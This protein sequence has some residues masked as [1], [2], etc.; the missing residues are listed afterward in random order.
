MRQIWLAFVVLCLS[1]SAMAANRIEEWNQDLDVLETRLAA[2][3]PKFKPCGLSPEIKTEFAQLRQN[4]EHLSDAEVSVAVQ[5]LLA[6]VGDGHTLLFPFG[7]K[8][9]ALHR[10]PVML[11][12][13][14]D[15]LFVVQAS[16]AKAV[17]RLSPYISHDNDMQLRWA[18]PFYATIT[19]FLVAIGGAKRADAATLTFD[20]GESITFASADIDPSKL[21]LKLPTPQHRD[22]NFWFTKLADDTLYIQL[23]AIADAPDKSLSA[24][25]NELHSALA[26]VHRAILDLRLNNGGDAR[27]ANDVLK[28]LIAFDT[29]GGKLAVLTS[30]MTFS[31]AQTLAT[32]LD[33]W[34]NATFVGEP[35]GSRPNHYGNERSFALPSS[36]LRG[37]IAS[38]LNQPI[39]AN[40]DRET[41]LPDVVVTQTAEQY[42]RRADPVLEAAL[43][44]IR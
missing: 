34:T 44:R 27:K 24:F 11:W 1:F 5:R 40:D 26:G 14:D 2:V 41:I 16:D 22:V 38:G 18:A 33:E 4:L 6:R 19:E 28:A 3:H 7:M 31:A 36:G 25:G 12:Q 39:T 23:N 17:R 35:T 20:D 32:R 10:L 43:N 29:D 9:G 13:F 8:R 42:F 21:D 30:R 37:T 15:G